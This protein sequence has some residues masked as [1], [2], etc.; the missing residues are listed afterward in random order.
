MTGSFSST[1]TFFGIYLFFDAF[2]N[3]TSTADGQLGKETFG[4]AI[5]QAAFLVVSIK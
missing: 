2:L 1:V 4:L 3:N 5:Y